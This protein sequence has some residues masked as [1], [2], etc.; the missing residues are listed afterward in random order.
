MSEQDSSGPA[1]TNR[2]QGSDDDA[3]SYHERRMSLSDSDD[4]ICLLEPC[5]MTVWCCLSPR[6]LSDGCLALNAGYLSDI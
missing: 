2:A 1:A 4:D 6:A 3:Q 5:L